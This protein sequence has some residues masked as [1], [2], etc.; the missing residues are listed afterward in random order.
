MLIWHLHDLSILMR[1]KH[2]LQTA[3]GLLVAG[4]L[5]CSPARAV[6]SFENSL[7]MRFIQIPAGSF[8]M[9][10]VEV[11]AARMELPEPGPGDVLDETPAHTVRISEPFYLGETEVTQGVWYR[12][13]ENRPGE[14]DFWTRDDWERLPMATASWFMAQRFVEELNKLDRDYRYRLPTEAEWEYAARAGS[15]G[16]RPV[17]ETELERYAWFINNSGDKPRPVASREANAFGLYDTLGN[18]WEWVADWYAADAYAES[19]ATD[20]QGPGEGFAKVRRGGSYHCPIHLLRPG[21]R[22]ANKPGIAYS[23]Q[24][25]RLVAELKRAR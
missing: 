19:A 6:D 1:E 13:M 24:G 12:V 5:I 21:Y 25:F 20:P 4:L 18:V 11:E 16:L 22:A 10:T 17:A 23:V 7:G 9:G 14:V 8:T 3:A 2:F 15:Q